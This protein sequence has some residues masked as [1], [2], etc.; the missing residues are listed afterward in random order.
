MNY[1][2]NTNSLFIFKLQTY[3]NQRRIDTNVLNPVSEGVRL[4]SERRKGQG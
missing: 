1:N 4:L 2:R 3:L